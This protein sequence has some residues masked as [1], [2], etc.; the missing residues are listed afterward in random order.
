M[1]YVQGKTGS[2]FHRTTDDSLLYRYYSGTKHF[3]Q[4]MLGSCYVT[5]Q[6]TSLVP[7]L[8]WSDKY[9]LS[10]FICAFSSACLCQ[11]KFSSLK[12]LKTVILIASQYRWGG[13]ESQKEFLV[14]IYNS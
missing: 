8:H 14:L 3:T 12:W 10:P 5:V 11:M 9:N 6:D 2:Y 13:Q 7:I 1:K 4:S